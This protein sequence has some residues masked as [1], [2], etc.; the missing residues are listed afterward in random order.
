MTILHK[1]TEDS[2]AWCQL[3]QFARVAIM[4]A[5]FFTFFF[6]FVFRTVLIRFSDR[7][8]VLDGKP[9]LRLFHRLYWTIFLAFFLL[10]VILFPA[11]WEKPHS[12]EF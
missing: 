3:Q 5:Y 4:S 2:Q 8:L 9:N 7:G 12:V 1:G 6:N 10:L 11:P